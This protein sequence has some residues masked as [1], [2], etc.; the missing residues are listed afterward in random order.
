MKHFF[1]FL[2]ISSFMM[3][4]T[5][6]FGQYSSP[7]EVE[8]GL[9]EKQNITIYF[10]LDKSDLDTLYLSNNLQLRNL[11]SLLSSKKSTGIDSLT[12]VAFASPEG[13]PDYNRMLSGKRANT[14]RNYIIDKYRNINPQNILTDAKGENWEGLTKFVQN[15]PLLPSREKVLN[16]LNSSMNDM[17]KQSALMNLDN[18]KIYTNYIF[19]KYYRLLRSGTSVLLFNNPDIPQS[20]IFA[21]LAEPDILILPVPGLS[22]PSAPK[23]IDLPSY[24]YIRPFA[25]KTNLL[26][27][28]AT[29]FN[30][31]LE[32]PI[33][34]HFSLAGE[35]VFPWWGGLGN[36]GGVSPVPAYSE[37]YTMQMLSGSL[38]LRYWFPRSNRMDEK[39]RKWSNPWPDYNPLCGWF[40]GPYVNR[41]IYDFQFGG[42]GIQGNLFNSAGL[43]IGFAHPISKY[44]HMEYA[45]GIGYLQTDYKRYTPMDGHKVYQYDGRYSW[46]GPTKA[47]VSLVWVPRFKI[48]NKKGGKI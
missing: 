26:F 6:C 28:V 18:G 16:I 17:Q 27:D 8:E 44:F 4:S 5:D 37:K 3:M 15:D 7:K 38:E 25:L 10:R 33:G 34:K 47:K 45:V 43:S 21:T 13:H 30:V 48:E 36:K 12:I 29:L 23:A 1:S 14:I 40:I 39:A 41:G 2:F 31:E 46:F 24:R 11:D 32:I 22:P 9:N 20:E 19:P 42:D 35:W